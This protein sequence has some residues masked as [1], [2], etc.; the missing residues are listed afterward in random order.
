MTDNK[1]KHKGEFKNWMRPDLRD[2]YASKINYLS[3]TLDEIIPEDFEQDLVKLLIS[4]N[5][6]CFDPTEISEALAKPMRQYLKVRGKLF[7]P[8]ITCMF[9]EGYGRNPDLFKPILAIS[10][11][12]HSCSLMLDDIADASL[13]RRGQECSH[14][15]YGI[16]RAANASSAMTSYA[17]NLL[18]STKMSLDTNTILTLYKALL[19]EHYITSIGSA[20][21]MGWVK[22]ERNS[23]HEDEY[24]QHILFRSSSYTY[25]HAARIGA[26]VAGADDEDLYAIFQYSSLLG[27]AFQ[28]L[29]DILNLRPG[30]DSW[31]K[32]IGE[33]ITEGK[34]SLLVLHAIKKAT[35]EDRTRLLE[36]LD[37]TATDPLVINEAIDILENYGAFKLVVVFKKSC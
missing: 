30:L 31:G 14:R 24:I 9:I 6:W 18:R 7:R 25:R 34:R 4:R 35:K 13:L 20:L 2:Y 3:S 8:L 15:I 19:W 11:I 1:A 21:D 26:I 28:F 5:I 32:T 16:S 12:I 17:F 27:V 22:E 33:D 29:D 23:I 37:G 10:E 36:I